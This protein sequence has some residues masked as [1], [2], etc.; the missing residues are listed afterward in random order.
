MRRDY[1]KLAPPAAHHISP[2]WLGVGI[3]LI[4]GVG[5]ALAVAVFIWRENPFTST[6]QSTPRISRKDADE[7]PA[8][9]PDETTEAP[10]FDFYDILPKN[11]SVVPDSA[12]PGKNKPQASTPS[13]RYYLQVGSFQNARDADNLK[14][15]LTLLGIDAVIQPAEI[16]ERGLWHRVRA[17]PFERIEEI[18]PVRAKLGQNNIKSSLIKVR[19][20]Q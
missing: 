13:V 17:G 3:G 8:Q 14:A 11:E 1:K 9:V 15:K 7:K 12:L 2:L 20:E 10:Q 6:S 5:I 4:L 18:E 19:E 16:P